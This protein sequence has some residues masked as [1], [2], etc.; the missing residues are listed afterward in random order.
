VNIY[1]PYPDTVE[2]NGRTYR[3]D[4]SYDNVLRAVDAQDDAELTD[5]DRLTYQVGLLLAEGER[6]PRDPNEQVQLLTAV[7]ALFPTPERKSAER[8]IDLHQDA[9]MIRS[10]FFRIGVDLLKDRIHFLQF[11]ELLSDLPSDTALMRTVE[12]RARPLPKPTKHN[13]AEIAALQ[14]AKARVA[15][16]MSDEERRERFAQSLKS[17]NI[18][19]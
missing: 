1:D 3:L 16:K 18:F 4:L 9:A 2:A 7:F 8:Y 13:A 11:I 14:K 10:A 12:I 17:S 5:G 15:I 6:V 19:T